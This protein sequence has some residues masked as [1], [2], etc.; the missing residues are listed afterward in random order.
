MYVVTVEF[1]I[2]S[3]MSNR[4]LPLMVENAQ[5]SL[6]EEAGCLQFDVSVDPV[7]PHCVFLYEVYKDQLEFES[8]LESAHFRSFNEQSL[9]LVLSKQVKTYQRL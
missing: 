4:F 9:S 7:N 8:H 3:G 5:T 1:L 2:H 6:R